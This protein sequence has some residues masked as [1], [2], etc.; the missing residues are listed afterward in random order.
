MAGAYA[1]L[2]AMIVGA[3]DVLIGTIVSGRPDT[4]FASTI[5]PF[6][7]PF[8]IPLSSAGHS[9]IELARQWNEVV[10][11]INARS[12]YPVADL[13]A[14][15]A[16]FFDLPFDTYFTDA[17]IMFNNYRKEAST[18]PLDAEVLECLAPVTGNWVEALD[19][20]VLP[21]IA[22]LFLIID[23][24]TGEPRFNF[25]YHLHRFSNE[26]VGYWAK[27]YLEY[28]NQTIDEAETT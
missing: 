14:T 26:L 16:A 1:K 4:A 8:P 18:L 19:N 24:Q 28:L 2:V 11:R 10:L 6:V 13:T 7:A 21:E 23:L 17:F 20:P 15:V 22:G 27:L 12:A 5:G 9:T 3:P 25:W